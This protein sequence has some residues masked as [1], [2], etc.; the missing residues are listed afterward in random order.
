LVILERL[1]RNYWQYRER[2]HILAWRRV[3]G[4]YVFLLMVW[5]VYRFLS[6]LPVWVEETL[7]KGLVFGGPVWWLT[8]KVEKLGF[9]SLGISTKRLFEAAY[10]GFSLGAFFWI[11][12]QLANILRFQGIL[13]IRDIQPTSA[14]FGGFLLLALV[15]AWWEELVFMGY[16]LPRLTLLLNQEWKAALLTSSLFALL[17]VPAILVRGSSVAQLII[18]LLLLMALG[19]G[20]SILMLRTRNLA[21]PI[22]THALWGVTMYLLV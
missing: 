9:A 4:L 2:K 12:G 1:R 8:F 17:Y 15:T 14:E 10:L 11:F 3:V 19:L 6:P 21:A 5:G 7:L 18:Q 20:N 22:L 16:L 13:T